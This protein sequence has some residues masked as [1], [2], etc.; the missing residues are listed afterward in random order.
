MDYLDLARFNLPTLG[1]IL[2][3][4]LVTARWTFRKTPAPPPAPEDPP[5]S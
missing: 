1:A 3:I 2:L 5:Q 4:G